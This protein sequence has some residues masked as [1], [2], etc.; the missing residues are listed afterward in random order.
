MPSVPILKCSDVMREKLAEHHLERLQE[1][2][3]N[4]KDL[5]H[6]GGLSQFKT[7]FPAHK[8]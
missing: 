4:K 8:C 1:L 3:A 2:K 6:P 5:P 7:T